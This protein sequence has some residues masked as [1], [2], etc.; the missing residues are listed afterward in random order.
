VDPTLVMVT[1]VLEIGAMAAARFVGTHL[2]VV[3]LAAYTYDR[4]GSLLV[5]AVAYLTLM[6]ANRA[7]VVAVEAGMQRW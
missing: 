7:V 5:R 2:A 6:V 1:V 3:A 4:T